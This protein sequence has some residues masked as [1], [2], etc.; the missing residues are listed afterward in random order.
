MAGH[1]HVFV[2]IYEGDLITEAR[3]VAASADPELCRHAASVMLSESQNGEAANRVRSALSAGRENAL[4][5]IST[6][7]QGA[8]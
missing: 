3:I 2:A 7:S 4:R 1:P 6:S 5:F 8:S